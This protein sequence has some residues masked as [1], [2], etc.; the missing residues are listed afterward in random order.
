MH[1]VKYSARGVH[2]AH[3]NKGIEP[4]L[5]AAESES[6]STSISLHQ[7]SLT[8]YNSDRPCVAEGNTAGA[9]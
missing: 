8:E 6:E 3:Q 4:R 1:S 2:A 9:V 5:A 7:I